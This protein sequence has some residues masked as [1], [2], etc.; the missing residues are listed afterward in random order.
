[1]FL[2]QKIRSISK[3]KNFFVIKTTQETYSCDH[4]LSTIPLNNFIELYEPTSPEIKQTI[5]KFKYNDLTLLYFFFNQ[6]KIINDNWIFFPELEYSFNRLSEQKS[7]S[8][9]TIPADKTVLCAEITNPQLT[10]LSDEEILLRVKEDLRKA[11]IINSENKD[12]IFH[13]KILHLKN[14][15]PIYDLQYKENLCKI[16]DFLD[17]EGIITLGRY[18]LFNYNNI[19][20]CFDMAKKCAE[21]LTTNK[22]ISEWKETRKSF[23][24]YKIVD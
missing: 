24:E 22:S 4:L 3:K 19:D 8:P 9:F 20:H 7:F 12:K 21:Y 5:A 13:L 17:K 2:D 15:Y 14:V 18:G 16:M 6:P 11:G 23:F 10:S 1:L